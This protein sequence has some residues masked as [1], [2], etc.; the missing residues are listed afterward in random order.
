MIYI[1]FNRQYQRR[2][3]GK[4]VLIIVWFYS[5]FGLWTHSHK[6]F[7]SGR[8]SRISIFD[9]SVRIESLISESNSSSFDTSRR[10]LT[11][12]SNPNAFL[13]K[14]F[15]PEG[16][17][18]I[19]FFWSGFGVPYSAEVAAEIAT[20]HNGVTLE[21]ILEWPQNVEIKQQ[22]CQWPSREDISPTAEACRT[23]WR[24]LSQVYA[25]KARGN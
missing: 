22:M 14:L 15:V 25:E 21:M 24:R 3:N 5:Y 1:N 18:P 17:R 4:H 16:E 9:V 2:F 7:S 6:Y 10:I 13:D 23:Q 8:C 11:S 12:R 20:Y 19:K